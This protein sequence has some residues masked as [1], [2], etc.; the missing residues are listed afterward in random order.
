MTANKVIVALLKYGTNEKIKDI[1]MVGHIP[2]EGDFF[3]DDDHINDNWKN[4][5]YIVRAV[6]HFR[7]DLVALHIEKYDV[8]A[9]DQKWKEAVKYWEEIRERW[10]KD[11]SEKS[12]EDN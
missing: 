1:T 3:V 10:H 7:D 2:N 11:G 4:N 5:M 12:E 8:D 9:E 6:T